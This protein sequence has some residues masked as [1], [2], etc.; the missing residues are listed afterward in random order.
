ML[1]CAL[2]GDVMEAVISSLYVWHSDVC[3]KLALGQPG[4]HDS[5]VIVTQGI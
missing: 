2:H 4:D 3:F 1:T 5:G